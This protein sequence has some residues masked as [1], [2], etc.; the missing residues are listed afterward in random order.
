[1]SAASFPEEATTFNSTLAALDRAPV[2][3]GVAAGV[4]RAQPLLGVSRKYYAAPCRAS[5]RVCGQPDFVQVR[6]LQCTLPKGCLGRKAMMP[7]TVSFPSSPRTTPTCSAV[8]APGRGCRAS[9]QR[10]PA[11]AAAAAQPAATRSAAAA[12]MDAFTKPVRLLQP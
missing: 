4:L 11:R 8:L 10:R 3:L 9:L 5:H 12:T 2:M 7:C 6:V 1:M